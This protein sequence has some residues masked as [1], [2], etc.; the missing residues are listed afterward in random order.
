VYTC[1]TGNAAKDI[2]K[3]IGITI[4]TKMTNT[5]IKNISGETI[6]AINKAVGFRLITKFGQKGAINL[7]KAIPLV[8]GVVGA[9]FDS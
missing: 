9:T 4:S 6:K 8:G 3:N 2:V 7:G 1:L 5:L